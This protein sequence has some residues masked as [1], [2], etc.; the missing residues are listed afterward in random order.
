MAKVKKHKKGAVFFEAALIF[1]FLQVY[2]RFLR[3][4]NVRMRSGAV[5]GGERFSFCGV[6]GTFFEDLG[7]GGVV[8]GSRKGHGREKGCGG[9]R[10]KNSKVSVEK[11]GGK[12]SSCTPP[13][14]PL[15]RKP[16]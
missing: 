6:R 12:E 4:R 9:A 13:K 8:C 3:H 10:A 14:P 2:R 16:V 7:C 5:E 1:Y 11:N 15:P